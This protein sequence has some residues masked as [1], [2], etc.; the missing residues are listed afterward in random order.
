MRILRQD[1]LI[2]S[3]RSL[4]GYQSTAVR[5]AQR[6]LRDCNQNGSKRSYHMSQK[7]VTI[8]VPHMSTCGRADCK[9]YSI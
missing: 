2:A 7:I 9:R 6:Q 4:R 1:G 8:T 3:L 5:T